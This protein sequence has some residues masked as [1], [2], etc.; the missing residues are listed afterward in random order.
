MTS[1]Y[2]KL[3]SIHL[4]RRTIYPIACLN[5][6]SSNLFYFVEYEI[7]AFKINEDDDVYYKNLSLTEG[8]LNEVKKIFED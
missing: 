4:E 3:D 2:I 7:V 5:V 1:K 6:L 8:Q